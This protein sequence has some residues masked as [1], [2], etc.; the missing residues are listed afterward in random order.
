MEGVVGEPLTLEPT[1]RPFL[2]SGGPGMLT[3]DQL[4][5]VPFWALAIGI[6]AALVGV[7]VALER[8]Q[9]W[10][11][12]RKSGRMMMAWHPHHKRSIPAG[13]LR[14]HPP[15][16]KSCCSCNGELP[17]TNVGTI[18]QVLIAP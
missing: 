12:E 5:H 3:L 11:E 16:R 13:R 9:P 6:A 7:L 8:L 1:V 18:D 17:S 2:L 15:P 14:C 10:H 4:A